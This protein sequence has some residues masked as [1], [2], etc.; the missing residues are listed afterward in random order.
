MMESVVHAGAMETRYRRA[1][2]GPQLLLLGPGA[3]GEGEVGW[4][5]GAIPPLVDRFRVF[6]PEVPADASPDWLRGMID[7]LGLDR[8]GVVA[9]ATL[10]ELVARFLETDADRLERVA[11]VHHDGA[12]GP[13][14]ETAFLRW[15][16]CP[17]DAGVMASLLAFL[18][19]GR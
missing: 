11:I 4:V 3:D 8:P 17:G 6:V 10:G 14:P 7:G 18:D 13:G 19:P 2:Q 15:F 5:A 16:R 12:S 1:G 9:D